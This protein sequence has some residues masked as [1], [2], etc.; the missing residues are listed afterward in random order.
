[1]LRLII[2]TRFSIPIIVSRAFRPSVIKSLDRRR[3]RVSGQEGNLHRLRP[4]RQVSRLHVLDYHKLPPSRERFLLTTPPTLD[5]NEP[6]IALAAP[7]RPLCAAQVYASGRKIYASRRQIYATGRQIYATRFMQL[8]TLCLCIWEP[9]AINKRTM[10]TA[11]V[12]AACARA[13]LP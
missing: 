6:N 13:F 1:M 8:E 5:R 7:L 3:R 9:E 12:S 2:A 10:R 4:V 11:R